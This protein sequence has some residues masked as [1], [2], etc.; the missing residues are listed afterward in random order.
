MR[1]FPDSRNSDRGLCVRVWKK[2]L[3]E[4]GM[5]YT[6]FFLYYAHGK[7]TESGV[8]TRLARMIRNE[9]GWKK[10]K[11]EE[12]ELVKQFVKK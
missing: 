7:L 4:M 8:I 5:D 12:E 6:F 1:E 11:K 3:I 9:E 10:P 2:E